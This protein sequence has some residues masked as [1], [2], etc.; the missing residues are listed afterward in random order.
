MERLVNHIAALRSIR[1]LGLAKI[2]FCPESNYAFEGR[3]IASDLARKRIPNVFVLSEDK[4]RIGVRTSDVLKKEMAVKF[5]RL[6][7]ERRVRF[8]PRMIC[9]SITESE[10]LTPDK[11]R[12]M[13]IKQLGQYTRELRPNRT[14]PS[15]P[16]KEIYS[17]KAAGPDD[18]CIAIQLCYKAVEFWFSNINHY[19]N[20]APLWET[21]PVLTGAI[22]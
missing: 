1:G 12:D 11:M 18:H 14:D 15:K 17:G 20:A 16:D 4:N 19:K 13:L 6:L 9:T 3:R 2:V 21:A 5:N 22:N 10:N 8:H 7:N